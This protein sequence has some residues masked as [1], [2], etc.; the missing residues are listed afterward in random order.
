MDGLSNG[1]LPCNDAHAGADAEADDDVSR[2]RFWRVVW[3]WVRI[4]V[5]GWV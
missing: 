1:R 2:Y 3:G 4:R 5:W